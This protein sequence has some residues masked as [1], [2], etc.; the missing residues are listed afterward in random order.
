MKRR[1][2]REKLGFYR[3]SLKERRKKK[4][5]IEKLKENQQKKVIR[6]GLIIYIHMN[7]TKN[8]LSKTQDF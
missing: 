8:E 6:S 2:E 5:H 3:N 1:N 7:R 4:E